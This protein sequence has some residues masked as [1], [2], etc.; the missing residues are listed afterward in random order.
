MFPKASS[1][2]LATLAVLAAA[3][4]AQVREVPLH[5]PTQR[6]RVTYDLG[7]GRVTH[8]APAQHQ[9]QAGIAVAESICFDNSGAGTLYADVPL[10]QEWVDWG[11]KDCGLTGVIRRLE[12]GYG[13]TAL[14]V[15]QGGPGASLDLSLYAGTRGAAGVLGEE[16]LR[17]S[18]TGLPASDGVT[19]V[20]VVT[21]IDLVAP[22]PALN[23]TLPDGPIGW[24]Y[25]STDGVTGPLLVDVGTSAF[26]PDLGGYEADTIPDGFVDIR[27]DGV[28]LT[29]T[30]TL[31]GLQS[32]GVRTLAF[33]FPFYDDYLTQLTVSDGGHLVAG[34]SPNDYDL[35]LATGCFPNFLD[36]DT[37]LISPGMTDAIPDGQTTV[38]ELVRGQA[39]FRELVYQFSDIPMGCQAGQRLTMQAVL[40][41]TTGAIEFHYEQAGAV[42][43]TPPNEQLARIGIKDVN[44]AGLPLS[45]NQSGG[46]ALG[47]SYRITRGA[48]SANGTTNL[49]NRYIAPAA[50][51]NFV[52]SFVLLDGAGQ[53]VNASSLHL[54]LREEDGS[55]AAA[56]VTSRST[57]NVVDVLSGTL[58]IL[59]ETWVGTVSTG[60]FTQFTNL[61]FA[62]SI[63]P[64]LNGCPTPWGD[65]LSDFT[66][67]AL[68]SDDFPPFQ[69]GFLSR[70]EILIPGSV[71]LCGLP[72]YVQ[73]SRWP[74]SS[75]AF[76]LTNA[77]DM[78]L[79]Y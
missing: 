66:T 25:T 37:P 43:C 11:R 27:P 47:Q 79:G 75:G 76:E 69:F 68:S 62:R 30:L 38:H 5:V 10:G 54:G 35:W 70:H 19:P 15:N 18:L 29:S 2:S 64:C 42:T 33:P 56:S 28:D 36:F 46:I 20:S 73:A 77:L 39:P 24:G 60:Q 13:T 48:E 50:S 65:F 49:L 34:T 8:V 3:P 59:G 52:G 53:I 40:F 31:P 71:D 9:T 21:I 32:G 26:G 23:P 12:V 16:V 67:Y 61:R 44:G 55:C 72:I 63:G 4:S 7:L 57:P 1:L 17:L 6:A 22:Y 78:V 51:T 41:E 14:D 74:G 58:P 45:C